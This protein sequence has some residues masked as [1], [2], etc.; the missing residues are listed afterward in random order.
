MKGARTDL[1]V[2]LE[3]P[4]ATIRQAYWGEITVEAGDVREAADL[5]PMF[6]GLPGDRCQCPHWGYVLK[7]QLPYKFADRE[8][9]YG[10]GDVYYVPAGHT[11]VLG[12]GCEYVESSPSDQL[13]KT[14][15]IVSRNMAAQ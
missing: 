14:M 8:E 15:E 1:P 13:A 10:P 9:V 11:P 3:R 12:A 4:E 7:G 2:V 6:T 5:A